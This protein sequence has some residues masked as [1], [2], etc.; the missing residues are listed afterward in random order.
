MPNLPGS[1]LCGPDCVMALHQAT[2]LQ[3]RG[4]RLAELSRVL[5][6]RGGEREKE[7]LREREREGVYICAVGLNKL[8]A[9][10]KLLEP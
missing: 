9:M 3:H 7:T 6:D 5:R 10:L 1:L 2:P 8:L 4:A